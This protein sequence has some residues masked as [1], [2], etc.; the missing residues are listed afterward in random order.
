MNLG[1][2]FALGIAFLAWLG[3]WLDGKWGTTPWMTLSGAV[4]GVVVGFVNFFRTALPKK[5]GR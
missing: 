3:H 4:L 5:E 1:L 2:S